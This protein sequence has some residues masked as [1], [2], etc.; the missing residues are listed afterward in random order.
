MIN[1]GDRKTSY[2]RK[3]LLGTLISIGM[4]VTGC[5]AA[6]SHTAAEKVDHTQVDTPDTSAEDIYDDAPEQ[7]TDGI[8][9][10]ELIK[11]AP[12]P[13]QRTLREMHASEALSPPEYSG[14]AIAIGLGAYELGDRAKGECNRPDLAGPY[15]SDGLRLTGVDPAKI[16]GVLACVLNNSDIAMKDSANDIVAECQKLSTQH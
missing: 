10:D 11:S 6:P 13:H 3:A 7:L 14:T 15:Y 1:I 2:P 4:L 5:S 8:S 12:D 16:D 9:C